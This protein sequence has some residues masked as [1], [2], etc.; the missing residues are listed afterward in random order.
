MKTYTPKELRCI[1]DNH[2]LWIL[3]K[4]DSRADLSYANLRS[5]DL[6]Y[7]DLR[8]A[9]L[10]YADL[11]SADLRYADLSYAKLDISFKRKIVSNKLLMS[12]MFETTND[13]WIVYKTFNETYP[14]PVKWKIEIGKTIKS[15][16][17][18]NR[19]TDCS[20]GINVATM[21][22]IKGN[23]Q[24]KIYKLL[25]PF[26]AEVCVPYWTDGKVRVSEAII[27]EML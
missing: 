26:T 8:S 16:I 27:L 25:V 17:D 24:A 19:N 3:G 15:I 2:R 11:R 7:A 22:W 1:L 20:M 4:G 9:D 13:G 23:C 18:T 6:S 14:A 10:S 12:K 5:A 21:D